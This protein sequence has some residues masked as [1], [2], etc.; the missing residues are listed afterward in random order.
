[1]ELLTFSCVAST[2]TTARSLLEEGHGL[3]FVVAADRQTEGRGRR[4]KTFLSPVGGLWMTMA[5]E[6]PSPLHHFGQVAIVAAASLA[7]VISHETG[8]RAE[9]KWPN[10]VLMHRRKVS[11]I[12]AELLTAGQRSVLLLG[13]GV[14]VNN[15]L[16]SER[17]PR[18]TSLAA[19]TG[20]ALDLIGLRSSLLAATEQ[21]I[22]VLGRDG[23]GS[24]LPWIQEHLALKG[25]EIT[26][27]FNGQSICGYIKR[28]MET[29]ALL[30]E[31]YDHSLVEVDAGSIYEW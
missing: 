1:M 16:P 30:L 12:L 24:F 25:E 21:D 28:I 3:P 31:R 5:M 9:I 6:V 20:Y 2:Q 23:F 17:L 19:E 10:D 11:G 27:T 15:T 22:N 18:A 13:I 7:Q 4:G 29:G 26:V 14:N 8:L